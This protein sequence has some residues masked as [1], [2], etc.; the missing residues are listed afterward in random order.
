MITHYAKALNS[1]EC[2]ACSQKSIK[3]EFSSNDLAVLW[4]IKRVYNFD[5][6]ARNHIKVEGEIIA[7]IQINLRNPKDL[8]KVILSFFP[9]KSVI[10]PDASREAFSTEILPTM[11][12]WLREKERQRGRIGGCH[13]LLVELKDGKLNIHNISYV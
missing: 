3:K 13:E 8:S 1:G 10:Y 11:K 12:K 9:I 7:S 2:F 4:G 6:C 5:S